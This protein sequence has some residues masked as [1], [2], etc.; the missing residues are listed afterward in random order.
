MGGIGGTPGSA[1]TVGKGGTAGSVGS[2][3]SR[4]GSSVATMSLPWSPLSRPPAP[5]A[6]VAVGVSVGV[7]VAVG[8]CVGVAVGVSDGATVGVSVGAG[9]AVSV[10]ITNGVGSGSSERQPPTTSSNSNSAHKMNN[11]RIK[12]L[13]VIA[14]RAWLGVSGGRR[15]AGPRGLGYLDQILARDAH[16]V[17][18]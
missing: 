11:C 17:V 13:L 14:R 10:A 1:G 4:V 2:C 6:D 18:A 16:S 5:G 7:G 12:H 15:R 3:G 8:V 9:T